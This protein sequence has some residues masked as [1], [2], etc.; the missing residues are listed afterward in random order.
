MKRMDMKI[1]KMIYASV[2]CACLSVS[3]GL[4]SCSDDDFLYQDQ[5]RVRL[6]GPKNYTAG[7]DSLTFSFA[8]SPS[9]VQEK[10]M[11]V[12]VVVMGTVADHDR[13]ANVTV[14]EGKTTAT[15]DQYDFPK[16]VV[17]EAG[18]SQAILPVTLRRSAALQTKQVKL[19]VKVAGSDDFAIGVNEENHLLLIW[20]D[21]ISKP[22]NWDDDLKEFFGNYSDVKYRFMLSNAEGITEF[23]TDMMSWAEL[24]SYKIKF[25]NALNAYNE[26][27]PGAPLTD[28][29]GVLVTFS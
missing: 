4:A 7:S 17:I 11:D 15:S 16:Q 8:T 29:N 1:R 20:S 9:D 19:C 27:H 18:K 23:D 25:A 2:A 26:A 5:A 12:E 6:V 3:L 24:Q 22:T 28:E 10:V 14:D 21:M 13:T